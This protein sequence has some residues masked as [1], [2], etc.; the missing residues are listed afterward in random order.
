MTYSVNGGFGGAGGGGANH[1]V[2]HSE[3]IGGGATW[4]WTFPD[5]DDGTESVVGGAPV[6]LADVVGY[7]PEPEGDAGTMNA[8]LST[9]STQTGSIGASVRIQT[10]ITVAAWVYRR[11]TQGTNVP[12]VGARVVGAGEAN[13]IQWEMGIEATTNKIRSIW[14]NGAADNTNILV[15]SVG[16]AV[17]TWE[18]WT[19]TRNAAGTISKLYK[20]GVLDATSGTLIQATGGTNVNRIHVGDNIAGAEF[21]GHIKTP[22]IYE[23]ELDAAEVLALYNSTASNG[24]W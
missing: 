3:S 22:I 14:Q 21:Q 4:H 12:I 23:E 5:G 11:Q 9:N 15:A 20:N 2:A 24:S 13:N 16:L 19:F 6:D 18:H 1:I 8:I 17:D 7:A 10:A